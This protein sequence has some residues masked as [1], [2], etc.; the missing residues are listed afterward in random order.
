MEFKDG[1]ILRF[2]VPEDVT[3]LEAARLVELSTLIVFSGMAPNINIDRM[4]EEYG[5]ERCI[6]CGDKGLE[7][8]MVPE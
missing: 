7:Y 5:V 2:H 1:R 3:P 8:L 6:T 4:A